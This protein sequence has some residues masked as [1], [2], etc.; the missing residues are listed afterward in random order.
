MSVSYLVP[1]IPQMVAGQTVNAPKYLIA[2]GVPFAC[3]PYGGEP[4]GIVTLQNAN[5]ALSAE[6]DVYTFSDLSQTMQ[7]SDIAELSEY[8][9]TYSVPTTQLVAGMTFAAALQVIATVFLVAQALAGA[10]YGL[11]A[12]TDNTLDSPASN[13]LPTQVSVG[14]AGA[15][16]GVGVGSGGSG[17]SSQQQIG[18]FTFT[19][20]DSTTVEQ[21]LTA[22]AAQFAGEVNLG[23]N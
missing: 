17:G 12:G 18:P 8:L 5:A 4:L 1:I 16:Q 19:V 22:T 20:G 2:L 13:V 15:G 21:L 10:G 14:G 7:P 3:I 11:F 9:A 23:G 6:S